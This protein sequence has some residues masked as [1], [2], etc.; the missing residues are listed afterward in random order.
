[1]SGPAGWQTSSTWRPMG[2]DQ[3]GGGEEEDAEGVTV[4]SVCSAQLESLVM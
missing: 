1:M 3:G 2:R 4:T